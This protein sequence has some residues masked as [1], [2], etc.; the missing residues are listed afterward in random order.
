MSW[1]WANRRKRRS[2]MFLESVALLDLPW[3]RADA[4]EYRRWNRKGDAS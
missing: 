1:F 3:T 2:N 4:K